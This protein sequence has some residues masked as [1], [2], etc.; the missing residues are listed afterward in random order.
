MEKLYEGIVLLDLQ[1][2]TQY[3]IEQLLWKNAYY[4]L[5]ELMKKE[6][7]AKD[8]TYKDAM[9]ELLQNVRIYHSAML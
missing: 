7:Y 4:Q 8:T 9:V 1:I 3:N 5:C 2:S 6:E